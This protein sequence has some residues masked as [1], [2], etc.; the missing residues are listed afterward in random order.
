[1]DNNKID[2]NNERKNASTVIRKTPLIPNKSNTHKFPTTFI[3][4]KG[5]FSNNLS[6]E[7]ERIKK[8]KISKESNKINS[9]INRRKSQNNL[10]L[11]LYDSLYLGGHDFNNNKGLRAN[12]ISRY[13]SN[14]SMYQPE[15]SKYRIIEK[16]IQNKLLNLSMEIFEK[17]RSKFGS[18][19]SN[20]ESFKKKKGKKKKISNKKNNQNNIKDKNQ[21]NKIIPKFIPLQKT[22]SL[23]SLDNSTFIMQREKK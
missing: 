14:L 23:R 4:Q 11:S 19:L 5:S 3:N 10:R 7:I 20:N 6:K 12:D 1:M 22:L 2:N 18:E 17:T 8:N 13:L 15:G 9:Q 16:N 21:K